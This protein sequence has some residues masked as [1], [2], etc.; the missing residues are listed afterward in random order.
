MNIGLDRPILLKPEKIYAI[1]LIVDDTI[2]TLYVNDVALNVRMYKRPGEGISIS[3]T[4]GALSARCIGIAKGLKE[5][6]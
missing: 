4:D 3:V 6:Q 5:K 2:G 1:C